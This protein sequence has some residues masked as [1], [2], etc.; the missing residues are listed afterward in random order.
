MNEDL[1]DLCETIS[2]KIM[3]TGFELDP[4]FTPFNHEREFD[5]SVEEFRIIQNKPLTEITK[6]KLILIAKMFHVASSG[7]K[8]H[9]VETIERV[10]RIVVCK[11]S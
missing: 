9:L 1:N 3:E 2:D 8:K 6:D 5:M 4:F 7:N 11:K 10:R